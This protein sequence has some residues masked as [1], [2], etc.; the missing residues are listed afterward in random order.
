MSS[1]MEKKNHQ[2]KIIGRVTLLENY[3]EFNSMAKSSNK[4]QQLM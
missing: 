2:Q 4:P 1:Q 3:L